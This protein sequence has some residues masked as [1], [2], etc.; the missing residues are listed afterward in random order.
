MKIPQTNAPQPMF[1]DRPL[2]A[3]AAGVL[4]GVLAAGMF[5]VPNTFLFALLPLAIGA[6]A[7]ARNQRML[8]IL[9]TG[10]ALGMLYAAARFP[11][12]GSFTRSGPMVT[13]PSSAARNALESLRQSVGDRILTLFPQNGGVAKGMLLGDKSGMDTERMD[14]FGKVGILHLLAVSGLHVS[15]LAGAF[16]LVIRKNSG[17]RFAVVGLFCLGYAALTAFSPSVLRA[18]I[19][20]LCGL[21]AAP[22]RR[23]ADG[24][25]GMA[26]AFLLLEAM[27]PFA[28]YR[29]GFQLSFCA[30][31]G[32]LVVRPTISRPL[33]PLGKT[34]A[35][36][37]GGSAAVILATIPAMALHFGEVSFMSL[38]TNLLVLPLSPVFL[39]P[40][41]LAT[42]A[43]FLWM[44]L[45]RILAV[46]AQLGLNMI[47]AIANAG[48]EWAVAVPAP[49]AVG[50][51]LFLAAFVLYSKLCLR[52]PLHRALFGTASL[53][54]AFLLW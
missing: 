42:A 45:G 40:A 49:G 53:A 20:L 47:V 48:G 51:L 32:L 31:F 5:G 34:A 10:A 50:Y 3:A 46:P 38:L 7:A 12:D 2:C 29:T 37:V 1:H 44:P 30:V 16:A 6:V 27:D 36:L 13:L 19:M 18:S 9:L 8:F 11:A 43:S 54:V 23:R 15:V 17:V 26:F 33:A 52:D 24:L 21:G 4:L 41:F 35:E 25:S 14:Q 22:L 39:I 28:L